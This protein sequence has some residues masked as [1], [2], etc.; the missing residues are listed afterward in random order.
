MSTTRSKFL[1]PMRFTR[2]SSSTQRP[3]SFWQA[4]YASLP[5]S[6]TVYPEKVRSQFLSLRHPFR[7]PDFSIDGWAEN[8]Q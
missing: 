4:L 5:P 6:T 1:L 8:P 7:R 3:G 2:L